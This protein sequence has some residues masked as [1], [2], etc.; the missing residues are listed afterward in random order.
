YADLD[1]DC[2]GAAD[3]D[4][5]YLKQ[6]TTTVEPGQC[7][8]WKLIAVNEGTSDALNTVITDQLTEFT[9][10]ESGGSLV[11]CRNTT[12]AGTVVALADA[13]YPLQSDDLGPLCLPDG[14]TGADVIGAVSGNTV[15]FT[16]GTLVPGDKA[17]GHFVV[18]VD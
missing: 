13:T 9:Q 6:H 18:K 15:T 2:D 4:K 10:F 14:T 7:I 11:S 8:V 17:I 5:N 3:T 16:V 1:T 12:D